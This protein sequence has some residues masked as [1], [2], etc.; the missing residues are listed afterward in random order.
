MEEMPE[1]IW[2]GKLKE[3]EHYKDLDVGG[4]IKLK[5]MLEKEKVVLGC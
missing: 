3:T 2:W 5:W 1:G 4:K